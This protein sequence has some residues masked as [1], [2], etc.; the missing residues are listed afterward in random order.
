MF[1]VLVLYLLYYYIISLF[2]DNLCG[3]WQR[4][5]PPLYIV[6]FYAAY[7]IYCGILF[8]Q[9]F[10]LEN[11]HGLPSDIIQYLVYLFDR[12]YYMLWSG[13]LTVPWGIL[14]YTPAGG[15]LPPSLNKIKKR[16]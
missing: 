1:S 3:I 15:V 2:G 6:V 4:P 14:H 12:I 16:G 7:T 8:S 9:T 13:F 11:P 5:T 10:V